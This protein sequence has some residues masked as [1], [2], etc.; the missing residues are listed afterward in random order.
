MFPNNDP[1]G[2]S[3][4]WKLALVCEH[5]GGVRQRVEMSYFVAQYWLNQLIKHYYYAQHKQQRI[6]WLHFPGRM[7]AKATVNESK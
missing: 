1:T 6:N 7:C 2:M 5:E 4:Q 3:K